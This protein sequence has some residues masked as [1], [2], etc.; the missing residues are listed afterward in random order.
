LNK[1]AF[2]ALWLLVFSIPLANVFVFEGVGTITRTIG[3][4]AFGICALTLV[5]TGRIRPL[6]VPLLISAAFIWW[7]ILSFFWSDAPQLTLQRIWTYAQALVM[8]W[9]IWQFTVTQSRQKALMQAYVL[10]AFLSVALAIISYL[11][12]QE[13]TYSRYA[14]P[15][16]NPNDFG[17][18]LC[19]GVPL[20]WYLS[21]TGRGWVGWVNR[22]YL[23]AAII[24]ILLTA[25]RTAFMMA[26]LAM[27]VIPW[28]LSSLR[29]WEKVVAVCSVLVCIVLAWCFVPHYVWE[30]LV[31][32]P[33]EVTQGT[34]GFRRNI[35]EAG[36]ALV[37]AQPIVGA[38][39]GTFTWV[40]AQVIGTETDAH[41][42][43]LAIL[44]DNGIIGLVLFCFI[45]I[46]AFFLVLRMRPL[47]RKVW[48]TL[49]GVWSLGAFFMTCGHKHW[50]WLL[51]GL[52][53][54]QAYAVSNPH[55]TGY[56]AK[57][58]APAARGKHV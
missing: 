41:N 44:A 48:L 39:A 34:L 16:F 29:S 54:T 45:G 20:S 42:T 21:I 32:I 25:S 30:R 6:P 1:V 49:L 8:A 17:F 43:F 33:S 13:A 5:M 58:N 37:Y 18:I 11:S 26:L 50:T 52:L 2:S 7:A 4:F 12:G 51:F 23:P 38:G 31:T 28:T 24:A 35:W 10:G 57:D 19:F 9:L 46:S 40:I 22:L 55:S 36:F 53:V 47:E 27:I 56:I 15:G 3:I 14:A